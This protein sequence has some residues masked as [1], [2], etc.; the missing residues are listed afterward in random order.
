MSGLKILCDEN[1]PFVEEA[2]GRFGTVYKQS[3]REIGA[4]DVQG[5]DALMVRSVTPVGPALLEGSSVRFVG[6]ATIGTDHVHLSYLQDADIHFAHAPGSNADSVA[7]YVIV[8]LLTLAR[9]KHVPLVDQTVGIVGYGNIGSRLAERVSALGLS[10]LCNDPPRAERRERRG[11]EHSFVGLDTVLSDADVVTLHVPLTTQGPHSTHHLIDAEAMAQ[12]GKRSWL[13]NTS[14]GAVVDGDALLEALRRGPLG[15]AVL[16]V[17][18]EEPS[19]D[20]ALVQAVDIATPH[21]AGY[22]IDGKVRGTAMLYEAFCEFL[23]EEATWDPASVLEPRTR[24]ALR[25]SPPDPRL[26]RT[27]WLYHLSCQGYDITVDDTQLRALFADSPSGQAPDFT[28]LRRNYRRRRELQ[29]H[30]LLGA[31]VPQQYREPVEEGI[32]MQID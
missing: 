14:R 15:A 16:D 17:W 21:I 4:E 25:P 32:E 7:D 1:I 31:S 10:V 20:P 18:E 5:M 12:M 11:E 28:P 24:D 3:G 26:P 27:D 9:R 2:F 30:S 8:A 19:P 22:A 29:Q 23:N 13:L 6:S